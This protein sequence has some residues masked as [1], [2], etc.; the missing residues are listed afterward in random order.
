MEEKRE[1]EK[2]NREKN[3]FE[4]YSSKKITNKTKVQFYTKH[5][6][7]FLLPTKK[8]I[9]LN[10]DTTSRTSEMVLEGLENSLI[11]YGSREKIEG[12][13]KTSGRG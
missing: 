8:K 1:M 3:F 6:Y 13:K 10:T 4:Q 12:Y 7:G 2:L 11:K 5:D 9:V